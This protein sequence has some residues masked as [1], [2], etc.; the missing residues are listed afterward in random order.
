[1]I[2]SDDAREAE[3]MTLDRDLDLYVDNAVHVTLDCS[4]IA[5]EVLR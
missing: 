4:T 2:D 1:M 3:E 5:D